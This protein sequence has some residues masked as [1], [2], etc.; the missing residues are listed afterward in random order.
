M[1]KLFIATLLLGSA[2]FADAEQKLVAADGSSLS[3][4]CVEATAAPLNI[5]GIARAH[6]VLP[7]ELDSIRCNNIPL[8][9]FALKHRTDSVAA[10]E[11]ASS[12]TAGYLLR[13]TDTSPLTELC[14][15]AAISDREYARVKEQHFSTES[16]TEIESEVLCNGQPLK[17]FVRKFRNAATVELIG[18]R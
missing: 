17:S 14:A 6:G 12:E 10:P 18:L 2:S 8:K 11:V 15:A 13:K 9:R 1:K 4:L 16:E 3:T 5:A 7:E